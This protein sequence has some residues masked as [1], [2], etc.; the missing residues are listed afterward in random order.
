MDI[1]EFADRVIPG[2]CA[3]ESCFD[4]S[5]ACGKIHRYARTPGPAARFGDVAMATYKA[6]RDAPAGRASAAI[7]R[8]AAFI[9]R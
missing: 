8:V 7:T 4:D 1:V 3:S 6:R 5:D 2:S 9:L